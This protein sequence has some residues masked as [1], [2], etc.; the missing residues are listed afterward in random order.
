MPRSGL[1]VTTRKTMGQVVLCLGCCCGRTDKGHPPVPV[2]YLK[3]EWKRR[4]LPKKI[5][6]SI[7]GCLGPCDA[8]NVVMI[9]FGEQSV[10]L[11]GLSEQ[12]QYDAIADWASECDR[13]NCLVPLPESLEPYR[14]ERFTAVETAIPVIA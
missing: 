13:Q 10:F 14:M 4:M 9:L 6:L 7:S 8:S 2:D 12:W 1:P 5:H 3:A 11:G